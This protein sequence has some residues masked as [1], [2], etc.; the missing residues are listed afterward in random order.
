[1][2]TLIQPPL[3]TLPTQLDIEMPQQIRHDQSHLMIR[4]RQAYTISRTHRK[5]L[6][7]FLLVGGEDGV[8]EGVGRG[9]PAFGGEGGGGVEVG[10]VVVGC[11]V[12]DA[13]F[14]L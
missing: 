2:T 8:V 7:D 6:Q 13:D 1:M 10:G 4:Q 5:G 14:D 11:V 9:E 12:G 3:I